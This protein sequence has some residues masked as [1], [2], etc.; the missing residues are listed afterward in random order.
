MKYTTWLIP[1]LGVAA[2]TMSC[3]TAEGNSEP[4]PLP[5]ETAAEELDNA[6]TETAEALQAM[7]EFTYAQKAEFVAKMKQELLEIQQELDRLAAKADSVGGAVK[8]EAET[9]L[10]TVRKQWALTKTHLDAVENASESSLNDIERNFRK[11]HGQLK[12]SF[13]KSRQWLSDKIEP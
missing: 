5:G 3:T 7:S 13:E 11:S 12:D 4:A 9:T 1:F 6:I 8:T 2:L 10:G